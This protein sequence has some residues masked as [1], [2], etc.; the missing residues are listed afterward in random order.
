MQGMKRNLLFLSQLIKKGNYVMFGLNDMK[1]YK[2]IKVEGTLI[3]VGRK[4]EFAYVMSIEIVY[5]DKTQ[6]N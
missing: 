1:V 2:N 5:I 3:M 6:K 4:M